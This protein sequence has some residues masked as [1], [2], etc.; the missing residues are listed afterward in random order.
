M[1]YAFRPQVTISRRRD[2]RPT[3]WDATARPLI[4]N[5]RVY[6]GRVAREQLGSWL[7]GPEQAG[8]RLGLPDDGPGSVAR[9][10]RRLA[11]LA[12]DWFACLLI[13][14]AFAPT[15]DAVL[16]VLRGD[17]L[18]T[19]AVFAVENLVLVAT[20]GHTLGQRIVGLRVRPLPTDD[21]GR[22]LP[23]DGR[24][25]GLLRAAVRTGL[26]LLVLPAVIANGDGRA[27]HDR[28][29]GTAIVRR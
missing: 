23:D 9:F 22:A 3:W 29:A 14:A 28:A 24:P 7:E 15:P 19:L 11:G 26:L 16:P 27:L 18:V 10:G 20:L 8:S 17:P 13:S 5:E 1:C 21:E 4:S 12:I 25:P 6:P 2:R